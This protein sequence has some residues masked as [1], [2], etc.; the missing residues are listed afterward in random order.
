MEGR[1]SSSKV[2]S[3]LCDCRT[4]RLQ[5]HIRQ[6]SVEFNVSSSQL[7]LPMNLLYSIAKKDIRALV[8]RVLV[9]SV[10]V[11][12]FALLELNVT[13]KELKSHRHW[14]PWFSWCIR[15]LFRTTSRIIWTSRPVPRPQSVS[16][17]RTN[18][19]KNQYC[20]WQQNHNE[21]DVVPFSVGVFRVLWPC[22]SVGKY[23]CVSG[24]FR[25]NHW[26]AS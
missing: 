6:I 13:A 14:I 5:S 23:F 10:Q 16:Q 9:G 21:P 15:G 22:D 25:H 7:R 8:T 4:L 24:V 18:Y 20:P 26:R 19:T 17:I 1:G 11:S 12:D 3:H 2:K